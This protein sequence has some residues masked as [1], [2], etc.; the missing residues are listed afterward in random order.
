MVLAFRPPS[1]IPVRKRKATSWDSER[2]SAEASVRTPN[3][4]QRRQDRLL[5]AEAAADEAEQE[6]A[7]HQADDS[8]REHRHEDGLRDVPGLHQFRGDVA[9]RRKVVALAD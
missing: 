3:A 4:A 8:S 9:H 6:R 5:P 7:H 1:L 2:A